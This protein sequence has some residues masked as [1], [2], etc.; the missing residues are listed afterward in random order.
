MKI[1]KPQLLAAILPLAAALSLVPAQTRA[2]T[3]KIVDLGSTSDGHIIVG[4]D[5][6]GQVVI[7]N[8]NAGLY[9]TYNDG[10]LVNTTSTLP[11]LTYD[12]GTPCSVPAGFAADGISL[13]NNG[14]T[15]FASFS[16]PNGDLAGLYTGPIASLTLI[17]GGASFE[18]FG[19]NSSGD[20]AF[21]NGLFE[22]NYEAIDLTTPEPNSL[23]LVGTGFISMFCLLR[24]KLS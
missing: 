8:E 9:L 14:R 19:L 5:N 6:L 2:D 22:E 4:I 1:P 11:S 17:A 3:Y 10:V 12:K 7:L 24:R 15:A 18:L 16:N 21:L 13:C 23:L 20:V